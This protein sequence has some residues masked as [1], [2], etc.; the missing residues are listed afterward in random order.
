MW[1]GEVF[2][3][4]GAEAT[5]FILPASV[6]P[7]MWQGG[8]AAPPKLPTGSRGQNQIVRADVEENQN[9][10]SGSFALPNPIMLGRYCRTAQTFRRTTLAANSR[11]DINRTTT[12]AG[13]RPHIAG[14]C[15][16]FLGN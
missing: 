1:H 7:L 8:G 15:A 3:I 4:S 14:K 10:Q 6:Q 13:D 12:L 2:P 9:G 11:A 5:R 16:D